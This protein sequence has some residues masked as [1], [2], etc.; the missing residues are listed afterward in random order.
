MKQ[1]FEAFYNFDCLME[2]LL[3]FKFRRVIFTQWT[4]LKNY[5]HTEN[6]TSQIGL[7]YS[8]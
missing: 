8:I 5:I 4:H 7:H 3:K 1:H 6:N 2:H